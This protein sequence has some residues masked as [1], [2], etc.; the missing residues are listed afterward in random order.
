[1]SEPRK[2]LLTVAVGDPPLLDAFLT[3]RLGLAP[4]AAVA[5]IARGA[6]QV[7]GRRC[8]DATR[9][10]AVGD[11]LVIH[12]AD[13][14]P[15]PTL[16]IVFVDDWMLVVE[17]PAGVASQATR[18]DAASALDAR[19]GARFPD[20]RMMHRLD[21]DASGLVLFARSPEARAPLQQSLERGEISRA[22]V[23]VVAGRLEGTGTIELRIGRDPRDERRRVAHP[24]RSTAGQP[25][26]SRYRAAWQGASTTL[27]ELEL[28]TGRTH[29]LRVHLAAIGHP[30]LGDRLYGGPP[31]ERL[32]LH[33]ARLALPH[34]RDRR[35][36][37][38]AS[39]P[40]FPVDA[41]P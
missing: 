35:P 15:G 4:A 14:A 38:L 3:A 16:P 12:L 2:K 37:E 19:I 39:P 10:L 7:G 41:L 33:A 6:V 26:L 23:A 29:Q 20:A 36:V 1:M 30:I 28:E 34:P 13:E 17:K 31:A 8:A 27:V 5:L 24:A 11:K 21:R 40:P 25:A 22:Y 18:G 9:E 32:Y